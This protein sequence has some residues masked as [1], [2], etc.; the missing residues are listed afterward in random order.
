[1]QILF[2]LVEKD[3]T[4]ENT[5]LKLEK[6]TN[7]VVPM[8]ALHYDPKYYPNPDK[9]DPERFRGGKSKELQY[10]YLPF[11]EGP[12]KC[13]GKLILFVKNI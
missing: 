7:V 12:R 11:G 6:G 3:Y 8:L 13:I 4:F 5:G 2:R 1:M 9:F 10:V